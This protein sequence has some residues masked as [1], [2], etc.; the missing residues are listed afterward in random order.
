[1]LCYLSGRGCQANLTFHTCNNNIMHKYMILVVVA[2]VK[3]SQMRQ[4]LCQQFAVE[5]YMILIC[6]L[7]GTT[8]LAVLFSLAVIAGLVGVM[9]C[10]II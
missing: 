1:M 9:Y 8:H 4:Q 2:I 5:V 7:N 3:R 10:M 6:A